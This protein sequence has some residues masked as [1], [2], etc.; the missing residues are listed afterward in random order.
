MLM[1]LARDDWTPECQA[2][3][4]TFTVSAFDWP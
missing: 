3:L 4:E 2:V 1:L